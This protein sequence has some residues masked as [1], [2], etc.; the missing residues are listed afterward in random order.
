LMKWLGSFVEWLSE[1]RLEKRL[2]I[3]EAACPS[4][5]V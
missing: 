1:I 3:G 4:G 5:C 2:R